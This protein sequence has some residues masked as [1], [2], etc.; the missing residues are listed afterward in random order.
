MTNIGKPERE[1]QDRVAA[2]F[3]KR[4]GYRHLGD[5]TDRTGNSN[6]EEGILTDWLAKRGVPPARI[7]KAITALKREA[8][9]AGRGL[10]ARTTKLFT[11]CSAT[12]SLCKQRRVRI[13]KPFS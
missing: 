11:I 12:A 9:H 5:W 7:A 13:T 2:F 3:V 10:Y 8:N 4:L 1:T 6:I